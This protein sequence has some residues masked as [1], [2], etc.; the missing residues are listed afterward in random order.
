MDLIALSLDHLEAMVAL[1]AQCWGQ[2]WQRQAYIDELTRP[3]RDPAYPD[4]A[5]SVCLGLVDTE[6][7]GFICAWLLGDEAHIINLLVHPSWRRQ[8]YGHRLVTGVI[9][10]AQALGLKWATLEVRASN[11]AAIALY[12]NLGFQELGR[13]PRYYEDPCEDGLIF[14]HRFKPIPA[15][16][17]PPPSASPS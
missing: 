10:Q 4:R 7:R 11:D 13:R 8:R 14:W 12:K 5:S 9:E 6:L 17:T 1:D 3:A 2:Y 15:S 16:M